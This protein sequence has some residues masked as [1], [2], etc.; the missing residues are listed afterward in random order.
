MKHWTPG[1]TLAA[2]IALITLTNAVALGG[3]EVGDQ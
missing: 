2:G 3:V 1:H